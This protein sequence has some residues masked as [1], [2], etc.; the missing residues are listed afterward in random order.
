MEAVDSSLTPDNVDFPKGMTF[1]QKMVIQ[2]NE[3]RITISFG[4]GPGE[5]ARKIE[6]LISTLDEILSHI[7]SASNTI[8]QAEANA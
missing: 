1:S 7:Y 5:D 4:G 3:L 8:E 2:Q 6:T